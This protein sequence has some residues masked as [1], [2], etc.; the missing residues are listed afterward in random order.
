VIELDHDIESVCGLHREGGPWCAACALAAEANAAAFREL[1][2]EE[3]PGPQ[4]ARVTFQR[5]VA[6]AQERARARGGAA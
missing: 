6:R 2:A 4:T 5:K 1:R 3:G